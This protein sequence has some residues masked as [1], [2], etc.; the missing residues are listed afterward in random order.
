MLGRVGPAPIERELKY[1]TAADAP[2]DLE[3]LARSLRHLGLEPAP[4]VVVRSRDRYYDDA[5]LSLSRA[6]LALR[7]RLS[8]GSAVATLKSR[9]VVRG[10]LLEREELELPLAGND[11]PKPILDRVARC[12]AP[13]LLQP[14]TVIDT[15]RSRFALMEGERPV[16]LLCFDSVSGRSQNGVTEVGFAEV[17]IEAVAGTDVDLLTRIGEALTDLLSLTPDPVNKLDRVR[18]LLMLGS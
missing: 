3:D 4:P 9:G 11:W 8:E 13:G 17:E 5:R 2:P 6:G 16:A 7:R 12:T 10:A 14:H 15:E 18:E 1:G